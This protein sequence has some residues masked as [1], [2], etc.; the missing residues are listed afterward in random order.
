MPHK[1]FHGDN[2]IGKAFRL[3]LQATIFV[4]QQIFIIHL[5]LLSFPLIPVQLAGMNKYALVMKELKT[6]RDFGH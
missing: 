4:I 6:W 3:I 2:R 1:L 5:K